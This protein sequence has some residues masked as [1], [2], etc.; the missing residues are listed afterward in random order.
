MYI[1]IFILHDV[2]SLCQFHLAMQS[3]SRILH[4]DRKSEPLNRAFTLQGEEG[5]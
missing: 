1:Q 2:S 3:T 5:H 4:C